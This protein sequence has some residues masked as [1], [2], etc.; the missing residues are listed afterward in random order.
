[1]PARGGFG[2]ASVGGGLEAFEET[3]PAVLIPFSELR[4][5]GAESLPATVLDRNRR[6]IVSVG[7]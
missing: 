3:G 7:R 2:H 6:P 1:M 5:A 4:A